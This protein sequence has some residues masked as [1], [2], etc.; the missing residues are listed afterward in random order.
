MSTSSDVRPDP[1]PRERFDS[2]RRSL[3]AAVV[4]AIAVS[5]SAAGIA[6]VAYS[7]R[8]SPPPAAPASPG[9]VN[10]T[11]IQMTFFYL[12]DSPPIFGPN[13]Q[14]GCVN[15]PVMMYG[16]QLSMLWL[17]APTHGS[18]TTTLEWLNI[19]SPIPFQALD[20]STPPVSY[21]GWDGCPFVT[22][23][24]APELESEGGLGALGIPLV[25][26]VPSSAPSIFSYGFQVQVD[27]TVLALSTTG[28][29]PM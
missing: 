3:I 19:S 13:F 21:G 20:C 22:T 11:S 9:V 29:V 10:L 27:V 1:V 7:S 2:L 8:G 4:V 16:G 24:H 15:C 18:N 23:F 5:L 17:R 28:L 26:S 6:F 14:E 12:N 25:F